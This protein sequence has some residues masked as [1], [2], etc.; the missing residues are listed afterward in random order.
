MN[1]RDVLMCPRTHAYPLP[2]VWS[3]VVL[4]QAIA[5]VPV[6]SNLSIQPFNQTVLLTIL[7][8]LPPTPPVKTN[9]LTE[10]SGKSRRT[11]KN[12]GCSGRLRKSETHVQSV[13]GVWCAYH[14][15]WSGSWRLYNKSDPRKL[16]VSMLQ[17]MQISVLCEGEC[18]ILGMFCGFFV[19]QRKDRS[20][21]K[22]IWESCN[23]ET[24][25]HI[26]L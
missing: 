8:S 3:P 5:F 11:N 19:S 16:H 10:I 2:G 26:R 18:L 23:R 24:Q 21:W 9:I 7:L 20:H 4:S 15:I 6:D 1:T 17:C 13:L 25:R 12:V 14:W 22:Q